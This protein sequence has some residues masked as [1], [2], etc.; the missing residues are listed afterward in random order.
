VTSSP[1]ERPLFFERAEKQLRSSRG[2]LSPALIVKTPFA[3]FFFP[4]YLRFVSNIP[5]LSYKTSPPFC[6]RRTALSGDLRVFFP[7]HARFLVF[8]DAVGE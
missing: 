6:A 8:V 5:K 2:N 1:L 4:V 7:E 3:F